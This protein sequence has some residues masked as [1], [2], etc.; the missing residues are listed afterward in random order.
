MSL[1]KPAL[2][3]PGFDKLN[4]RYLELNRRY[5]ELNRRYLELN[6]RHPEFNPRAGVRS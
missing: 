1:S 6:R 3:E 2:E 4:R 5:L